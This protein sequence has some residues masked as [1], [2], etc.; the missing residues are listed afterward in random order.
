MKLIDVESKEG[1]SGI[2]YVENSSGRS[3]KIGPKAS[4]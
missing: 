4:L 1:F 3:L 2:W